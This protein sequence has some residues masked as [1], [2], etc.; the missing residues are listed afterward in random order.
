MTYS[1]QDR[2]GNK[3]S[4]QVAFV[5]GDPVL[6]VINLNGDLVLHAEAGFPF[7]DPMG[8][9]LDTLEGDLSD[10]LL[11]DAAQS[12]NTAVQGSYTVKY[13]M[14]QPDK[15]GLLAIPVMR[16]VNVRDTLAPVRRRVPPGPHQLRL[17]HAHAAITPVL[18]GQPRT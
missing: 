15:Q 8:S 4:F 5:V 13:T 11:S 17:S 3:A 6:P 1:A 12:V 10:R 2:A 16:I 7:A 14:A 9:I 18:C